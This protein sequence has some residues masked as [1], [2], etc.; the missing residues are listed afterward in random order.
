MSNQS[1]SPPLNLELWK[2]QSFEVA[3]THHE[4][5]LVSGSPN[6]QKDTEQWYFNVQQHPP[7]ES[8]WNARHSHRSTK[9]SHRSNL[10]QTQ[11]ATSSGPSCKL[12]VV[13]LM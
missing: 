12:W 9:Y 3:Q 5:I 1:L 8:L 7:L 4:V 2:T 11:K 6:C 13:V 10:T